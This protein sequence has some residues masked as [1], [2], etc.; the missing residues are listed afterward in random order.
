MMLVTR[1]A[2]YQHTRI[3]G[4]VTLMETIPSCLLLNKSHV[5]ILTQH[6]FIVIKSFTSTFILIQLLTLKCQGNKL[7]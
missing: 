2:F 4:G 7:N 1:I 3:V 6:R 5:F